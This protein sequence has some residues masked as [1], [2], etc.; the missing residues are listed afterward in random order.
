MISIFI[1]LNKAELNLIEILTRK[2]KICVNQ[3]NI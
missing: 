2:Q 3:M 1:Y